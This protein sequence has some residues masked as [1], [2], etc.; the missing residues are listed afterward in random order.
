MMLLLMLIIN[1][2]IQI[3]GSVLT[4]AEFSFF[5]TAKVVL[6]D[7]NYDLFLSLD[8]QKAISDTFMGIS[9]ELARF[10]YENKTVIKP[11][12]LE[13]SPHLYLGDKK[14]LSRH[15]NYR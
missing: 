14:I 11:W 7:T 2:S 9:K 1:N 4:Q 10:F 3:K 6:D 8:S 12:L 13:T 15:K 5:P